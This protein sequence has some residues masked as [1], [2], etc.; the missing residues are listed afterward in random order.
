MLIM[1]FDIVAFGRAAL[2]GAFGLAV[3]AAGLYLAIRI[4]WAIMATALELGVGAVRSVWSY[5]K[6]TPSER[7][8]HDAALLA[9]EAEANARRERETA[10]MAKLKP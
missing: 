10:L 5:W 6:M 2:F 4:G 7:A 9:R 8:A 1:N 3:L